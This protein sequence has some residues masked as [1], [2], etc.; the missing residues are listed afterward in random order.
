MG[1][2]HHLKVVFPDEFSA[3]I[4]EEKLAGLLECLVDDPRPS[5]QEDPPRIYGMSFADYQI[6]F[7]VEEDTLTVINIEKVN[8][9]H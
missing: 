9:P 6:K 2:N 4:P 8:I 1:E 7:R 5:Y 3:L